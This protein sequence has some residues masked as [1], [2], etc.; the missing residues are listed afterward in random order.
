MPPSSP[1][2]DCV[3]RHA[4]CESQH[5]LSHC[6][7][8]VEHVGR[9]KRLSHPSQ[10]LGETRG[11]CLQRPSTTLT[12]LN[13]N[14]FVVNE[15]TPRNA[16]QTPDNSLFSRKFHF[17]EDVHANYA[18]FRTLVLWIDKNHQTRTARCFM[19]SKINNLRAAFWRLAQIEGQRTRFS[20]K[21]VGRN[22]V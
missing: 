6:S 18:D 5:Y 21:T 8:T 20:T 1:I 17:A 9:L 22:S 15:Q 12:T 7:L 13:E 16:N 10:R 4:E 2:L 14:S 11:I 3:R 19:L